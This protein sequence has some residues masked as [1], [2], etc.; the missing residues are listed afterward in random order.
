MGRAGQGHG[1]TWGLNRFPLSHV[2]KVVSELFVI[3]CEVSRGRDTEDL[4]GQVPAAS[5][6]ALHLCA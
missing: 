3:P 5:M 1:S 6:T 4:V 2:A